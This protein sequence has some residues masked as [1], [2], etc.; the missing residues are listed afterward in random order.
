MTGDSAPMA[1][2][3]ANEALWGCRYLICL[4]LIYLVFNTVYSFCTA[5]SSRSPWLNPLTIPRRIENCA[6]AWSL[7]APDLRLLLPLP[8]PRGIFLGEFFL[9]NY[10]VTKYLYT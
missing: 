1:R 2:I 9:V 8:L 3:A 5:P 7:P 6:V 10:K 4:I